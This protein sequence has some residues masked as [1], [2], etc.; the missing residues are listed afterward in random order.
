MSRCRPAQR[1]LEILGL[2]DAFDFVATR[3]DVENGKPDLEIC[4]L[5]AEEL[6]VQV[7]ECLVIEDSPSGVEA[8]Q[9]AGMHVIAASTPFTREGLHR[10]GLLPDGHI[11]D[12]PSDL[13]RVVEH[14]VSEHA[15]ADQGRQSRA[16]EWAKSEES[17]Q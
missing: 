2:E 3:D 6:G 10:S 13:T 8:A 4:Q 1:V 5:V 12:D 11:V 16:H 15:A 14:I 7:S 17:G 9:A